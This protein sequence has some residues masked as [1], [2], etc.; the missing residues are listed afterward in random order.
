MSAR[1]L[2]AHQGQVPALSLLEYRIKQPGEPFIPSRMPPLVTVE[3][4]QR[5]ARGWQSLTRQSESQ[6]PA[7]VA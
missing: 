1:L 5:A 4:W 6:Y 7:E 3:D 2:S